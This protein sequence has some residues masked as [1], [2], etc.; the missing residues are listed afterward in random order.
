M[1]A[2]AQEPAP[3][4]GT[5]PRRG[6]V[7]GSL[8]RGLRT[9]ARGEADRGWHDPAHACLD[10][11]SEKQGDGVDRLLRKVVMTFVRHALLAL[12]GAALL[13]ACGGGTERSPTPGSSGTDPSQTPDPSSPAPSPPPTGTPCADCDGCGIAG[14]VAI[15]S[16]IEPEIGT[17]EAGEAVIALVFEKRGQC[18]GQGGVP[19]VL[20]YANGAAT[21][22]PRAAGT[23][24]TTSTAT[25]K[26]DEY[27]WNDRD[28]RATMTRLTSNPLLT[29]TFTDAGGSVVTRCS[30]EGGQIVCV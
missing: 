27:V 1:G 15:D 29:I 18:R 23:K 17:S 24:I 26:D 4:G 9:L 14:P 12:G 19:Y 30:L 28:L 8:P 11:V 22:T 5:P 3:L 7:E 25:Y 6:P 10:E 2:S 16:I 20:T 21:L 13:L